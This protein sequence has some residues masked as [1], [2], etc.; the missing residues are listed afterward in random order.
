MRVCA[1]PSQA[2]P[3]KVFEVIIIKLGMVTASD[4]LMHHVLIILTLT[5]IQGHTDLYVNHEKNKCLIISEIVQAVHITVKI[6]RPKVCISIAS[7]MTVC[8]QVC[9][10]LDYFL[11]CNIYQKIF[12]LLHSNLA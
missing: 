11:T 1:C 3:R 4:M 10:G 12:K 6:V 2:I 9:L 7:P 5:F 8:M